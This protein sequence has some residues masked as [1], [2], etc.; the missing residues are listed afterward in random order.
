M[1]RANAGGVPTVRHR[2]PAAATAPSASTAHQG[3]S[4]R[5]RPSQ[6]PPAISTILMAMDRARAAYGCP[7]M[8]PNA[9]R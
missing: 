4:A 3:R 9:V 2:P 8:S 6:H 7:Y 5:Y 1:T